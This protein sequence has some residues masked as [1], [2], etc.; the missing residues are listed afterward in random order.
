MSLASPW[1]LPF[2]NLTTSYHRFYNCVISNMIFP[3]NVSTNV[4]SW[5]LTLQYQ[6]WMP[7]SMNTNNGNLCTRGWSFS[8]SVW[9]MYWLEVGRGSNHCQGECPLWETHKPTMM[10]PPQITVL[11]TAIPSM[12]IVQ[13]IISMGVCLS[14]PPQITVLCHSFNGN[15]FPDSMGGCLRY[16]ARVYI[17]CSWIG[18]TEIF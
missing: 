15:C 5:S 9:T 3:F 10:A 2:K 11:C 14:A 8:K 6:V 16:Q 18:C 4:L 13:D 1:A 17:Q 12:V 7:M